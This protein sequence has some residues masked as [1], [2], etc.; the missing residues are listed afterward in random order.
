M[1]GWLRASSCVFGAVCLAAACGSDPARAGADPPASSPSPRVAQAPGGGNRPGR[2][3]A[4]Q[5]TIHVSL[6]DREIQ[7]V[8]VYLSKVTGKG[9]V[10]APTVTGKITVSLQDRTLDEVLRAIATNVGADYLRIGEI[11]YI[12]PREELRRLVALNGERRILKLDRTSPAD[13]AATLQAQLPYLTVTSQQV[14][15][16]VIVIGRPE[17]ID[18]AEELVLRLEAITP[19]PPAPPPPPEEPVLTEVVPLTRISAQELANQLRIVS[20]RAEVRIVNPHAVAIQGTQGQ[21][22]EV[23]KHITALDAEPPARP[24]EKIFK[25]YRARYLSVLKIKEALKEVAPDVQVTPA[26]ENYGP[27]PAIFTPLGIGGATGAGGLGGGGLGGGFGGGFGGAVGA[28]GAGGVSF[29]QLERASRVIL[30][31]DAPSVLRALALLDEV[32]VR[33]Q[34]VEIEAKVYEL[35]PTDLR[36]IGIRWNVAGELDVGLTGGSG[37]VSSVITRGSLDLEARLSALIQQ[38]RARLMASPRTVVTDNEDSSIFIGD[39][40]RFQVLATTTIAG[41]PLFTVEQTPAGIALLVRPR[42]NT[43]GEITLKVHPAV[44]SATLDEKGL[45]QTRTREVDTTVRLRDGDT[46]A[47][48]GLNQDEDTITVQKLPL[49]GDIPLVGKLF[50]HTQRFRRKT[51]VLILIRARLVE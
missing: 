44:S 12:A 20:P 23:R 15:K 3:S 47:I 38:S 17:D 27:P 25:V 31:G 43:N 19:P 42:V 33:P 4:T 36:S 10:L 41:Q 16:S 1:P 28:T 32:D 34:Q 37:I 50:R 29:S 49:L 24:P 48:G 51:E 9:I 8:V 22:A 21:I 14:P 45:P 39:V 13:V 30:A 35:S 2:A 40:L 5:R 26:P 6:I 18:A 11:Y 46:F 7:E